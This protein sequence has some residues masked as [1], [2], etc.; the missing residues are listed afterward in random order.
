MVQQVWDGTYVI[1]MN[2]RGMRVG[3]Q[4]VML[5]V[6]FPLGLFGLVEPCSCRHFS[7]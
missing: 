6:V 1:V 3:P 2:S 7:T 5:A 4:M